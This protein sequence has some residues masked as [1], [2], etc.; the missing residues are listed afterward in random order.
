MI[1]P[2][3]LARN[4]RKFGNRVSIITRTTRMSYQQL[5]AETNRLAHRLIELG[6]EKGNRIGIV[7]RNNEQFLRL[8]FAILKCGG[9]VLPL[10][11]HFTPRELKFVI[12]R[13]SVFALLY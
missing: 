11:V 2:K 9:I 7:A 5:E 1:I 8:Y 3:L 12:D 6:I 10:N 4:A 13:F